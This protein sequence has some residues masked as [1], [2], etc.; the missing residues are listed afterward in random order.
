MGKSPSPISLFPSASGFPQAWA[1]TSVPSCLC[2]WRE[3]C[4]L[5]LLGF[6]DGLGPYMSTSPF[7]L[8][9]SPSRFW[10]EYCKL[11]LPAG[12]PGLQN[13]TAWHTCL[14]LSSPWHLSQAWNSKMYSEISSGSSQYFC[15]PFPGLKVRNL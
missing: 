11:L 5:L 14:S 10:R 7:P 9:P 1:L 8:S 15:Y 2:F 3:S 4:Q 6:G 12:I 13:L